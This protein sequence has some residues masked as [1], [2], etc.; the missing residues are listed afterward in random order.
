MLGCG[1]SRLHD[2]RAVVTLD[3][4]PLAEAEITLLPTRAIPTTAFGITDSAGET[5]FQTAE[6]EGVFPGSYVAV[7]SKSIEERKLTNNEIR[8]LA[9][10][11]IRYR[12]TIVELLPERYTKRET[13]DLRVRIGYWH[14]TELSFELLSE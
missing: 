12:P 9:E 5:T 13:S 6:L 2:V 14:T 1:S 3:G 11:G 7:V 4:E 10:A 8:A